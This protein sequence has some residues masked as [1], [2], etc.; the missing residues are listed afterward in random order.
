[1]IY[2]YMLNKIYLIHLN[3]INSPQY[4]IKYFHHLYQ[5]NDNL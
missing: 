4:I 5:N 2:I 3:I 1:M